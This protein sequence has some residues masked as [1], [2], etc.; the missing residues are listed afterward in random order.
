MPP[1]QKN[2]D[3]FAVL[4]AVLPVARPHAWGDW[5]RAW[6]KL[7]SM[8]VLGIDCGTEYTGYGVVEQ[9]TAGRLEFI[10]AGAIH[11]SRKDSMPSRLAMVFSELSKLILTNSPQMF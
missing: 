6:V 3:A 8:R 1:A 5:S 2:F 4:Q 10:A 9:N 11:L 7:E